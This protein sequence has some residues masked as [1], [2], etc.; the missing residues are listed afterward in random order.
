MFDFVIPSIGRASLV[1]SLKSLL[2]QSEV[3]WNCY[4]GFD[5]LKEEQ[6]NKEYLIDDS[7]IHYLYL[8]EKLG[9]SQFHGN[10]GLVRN[11]IIESIDSP[12]EW[13]GFLDDDDSLAHNYI[14]IIKNQVKICEYDCYVFRMNHNDNI[15]PPYHMMD[16][17][18]NHVG[19]SFCVRSEFINNNNI[20][21]INDNDEDF[22][23]LEQIHKNNG[24]IKLLPY[25]GYFV[26]R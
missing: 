19:I 10:A 24:R 15:I 2:Q 17:I 23:F 12:S 6:I 9:R 7:R 20:K 26:G 3:D 14:E 25:V 4:V 18:Q 13:I 11:K 22:K 16:L 8:E 5:G 21:F 1:R